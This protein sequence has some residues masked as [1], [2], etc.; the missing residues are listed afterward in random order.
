MSEMVEGD[1]LEIAL[2][3]SD[4]SLKVAQQEVPLASFESPRRRTFIALGWS[5]C[6]YLLIFLLLMGIAGQASWLL[7]AIGGLVGFAAPLFLH[8][9]QKVQ[10]LVIYQDRLEAF[11]ANECSVLR[12]QDI[13]IR[14]TGQ[15]EWT[16]WGLSPREAN[17]NGLLG[18][19][20]ASAVTT[21]EILLLLKQLGANIEAPELLPNEE[22]TAVPGLV[23]SNAHSI[24]LVRILS[25][26]VIGLALIA[27][28]FALVMLP[29]HSGLGAAGLLLLICYGCFKLNQRIDGKQQA[30]P[31][32]L[33]FEKDHIFWMEKGVEMW[34]VRTED[35]RQFEIGLERGYLIVSLVTHYGRRHPLKGILWQRLLPQVFGRGFDL[36][37]ADKK[38]KTEG[39]FLP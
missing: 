10:K 22:L 33:L 11:K 13:T 37:P 9:L 29:L 32:G 17:L 35:V 30:A 36:V 39:R 18:G 14:S 24:S 12:I 7:L 31:T 1:P 6:A 38:G 15:G 8:F 20:G 34:S 28:I 25:G 4:A 5:F 23:R 16:S 2:K 27:I 19:Q 26:T 3:A 21:L